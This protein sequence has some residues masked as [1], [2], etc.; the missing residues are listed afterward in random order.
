MTNENTTT[1]ENSDLDV[2]SDPLTTS[3]PS[4][5]PSA[6]SQKRKICMPKNPVLDVVSVLNIIDHATKAK[7]EICTKL[8]KNVSEFTSVTSKTL[9]NCGQMKK[10][11]L[12]FG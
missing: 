3:A 6:S 8:S 2:G 7:N 10:E 12:Q 1:S 5:V 11:H 9:S 4:I